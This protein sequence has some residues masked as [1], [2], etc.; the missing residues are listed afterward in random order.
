MKRQF[1]KLIKLIRHPNLLIDSL[2]ARGALNFV[3]DKLF[4][5]IH[6]LEK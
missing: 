2:L 5:Q 4:L 1:N 6:F 3:P